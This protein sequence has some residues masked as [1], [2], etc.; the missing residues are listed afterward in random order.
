MKLSTPVK[1]LAAAVALAAAGSAHALNIS[2]FNESQTAQ[3]VTLRISGATAHDKGLVALLRDSAVGAQVCKPNTLDIYILSTKNDALYF[4][5]GGDASGAQDK[6]LAIFKESD[7]GS[8]V[9]VGP[10]VRSSSTLSIVDGTT[11]TRNFIDPTAPALAASTG[12]PKSAEGPLSAYVEHANLDS[13]AVVTNQ[14]SDV[15]IS[16]VEP[17]QFKQ[18][19][20]PNLTVNELAALQVNGI[21]SV[22]FGVPVTKVAYQRLQAIQFL[23][24]NK[25]NPGNAGYG[26]FNSLDSVASSEACM[27][28]LSR[29]TLAG[30]YTGR[31]TKWGQ[32]WSPN[33]AINVASVAL[34]GPLANTD[35]FI[36]RRVATSGTERSFEIYFAGTDC[37]DG[38][39]TFLDKTNARVTEN[40]GTSNVV[41]GL[42]AD[43]T[44]GKASIG[45]LTSERVPTTTDGWRFIKLDGAAPNVLN[46][47]KGSHEFFFES[48]IQWRKTAI[49]SGDITLPAL[50]TAKRNVAQAIVNQLGKPDVVARL[51]TAFNHPF[52]R[53]GLLGNAVKNKASAPTTPYIASGAD[54]TKLNDVYNRP[55]A[56]S[57]RGVS[58]NPNACRLT[59][60]VSN[61]A[62]SGL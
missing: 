7:G 58:G 42:N 10:L 61:R 3:Q 39:P 29:D 24:T 46:A 15:G 17:A 33:R 9:G 43:N 40:S 31:I 62:Q 51:N 1:S 34:P 37:V 16:D 18:I 2:Q 25:C 55:I 38:A 50:P 36:Q 30:I 48:T 5:T 8:G 54:A 35:I 6:R 32:I 14:Q 60:K 11:I 21:S 53:A 56:T 28:S 47:V 20:D 13:S 59:V 22:I 57:T 41:S 49:V 27:P 19:Y 45:V 26:D 4:C 23:P 44:A 12:T 52:G